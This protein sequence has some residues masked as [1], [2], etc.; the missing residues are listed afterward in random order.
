MLGSA[1]VETS[2]NLPW[3]SVETSRCQSIRPAGLLHVKPL[4]FVQKE[5]EQTFLRAVIGTQMKTLLVAF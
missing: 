4:F 5:G 1:E 2:F 3:A